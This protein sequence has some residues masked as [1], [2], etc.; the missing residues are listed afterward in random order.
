[1]PVDIFFT[2][3]FFE[4]YFFNRFFQTSLEK[5]IDKA[6]AKGDLVQAEALSDM[7]ATREVSYTDNESGGPFSMTN[8]TNSSVTISYF[9]LIAAITGTY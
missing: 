2:C 6:V 8:Y 5:N 3:L 9:I 4:M 7:L 1:M